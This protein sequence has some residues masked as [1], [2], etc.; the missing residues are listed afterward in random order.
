MVARF[1]DNL[2][3]HFAASLC[4]C[5]ITMLYLFALFCFLVIYHFYL[6]TGFAKQSF[7]C[8]DVT[9]RTSLIQNFFFELR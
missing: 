1:V 8:S 5:C 2:V 3:G 4:R 6:L 7:F 9:M